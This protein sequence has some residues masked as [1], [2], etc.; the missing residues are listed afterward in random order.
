M[1]TTENE[2]DPR[3]PSTESA[4]TAPQPESARP[5]ANAAE[6]LRKKVYIGFAGSIAVALALAGLYVGGRVFAARP[7]PQSVAVHNANTVAGPQKAA[8]APS[9]ASIPNAAP[10]A[11]VQPPKP[12][13]APASKPDPAGPAPVQPA[14][15]LP[16]PVQA[17]RV[18]IDPK[19]NELYLQL[20]ALGPKALDRYLPEVQALHP[21]VAP[22]PDATT[23]R[24]L[25]G[26]FPDWQTLG[27]QEK[28]LEAKGMQVMPRRY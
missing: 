16:A 15:Q 14:A 10:D 2:F 6:A 13:E 18:L 12:P 23:F 4:A 9:V 20:A 7:A 28:E 1:P 5:Q 19:P 24:V 17:A 27:K 11:S 3:S 21:L 25:I 8:A 26:P 22:G